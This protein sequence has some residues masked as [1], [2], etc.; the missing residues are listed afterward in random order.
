MALS[1]DLFPPPVPETG[2]IARMLAERVDACRLSPGIAVGITEAG[3]RRYVTHGTS[4]APGSRAID[5]TT[6]FEIGSITKLF[7]AL[8]LAE[9]TL[10]G[11]TTL[12][13]PV[14]QLLP[15]GVSVPAWQERQ[16][17]LLD[18]ATH[19]SGL[20]RLPAN[21]APNDPADPYAHYTEQ[22]LYDFLASH[23]LARSPAAAE[24]YSNIGA[25]LLGHALALRAGREYEALVRERILRPLGMAS[26]VLAVPPKLAVRFA[27]GHDTNPDPVPHWHLTTLAGAGG[28]RS[29]A[30]DL[31]TF[32]EMLM[33]HE[34]SPLGPAAALLVAPRDAGGLGL[35]VAQPDGS[36]VLSHGGGTGGFR[37]HVTCVAQ[38]RRGVA[39]LGNSAAD[40]EDLCAY[41]RD[42]RW[43][44]LWHRREAKVDPRGFTRLVGRYRLKPQIVIDVICADGHLLVQLSGQE[45]LRVFPASE[46]H[47]FYKLIGAQL[48]FEPGPDGR[49]ARL[50]LHQNNID[51]IAERIIPA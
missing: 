16:I 45:A 14:V 21:L 31:M 48:T 47:F 2:A 35:G 11:E 44:R 28:L 1:D 51:R 23:E 34:A 10:R 42:T 18:L 32:L 3:Q 7:T 4:G 22:H 29:C 38:W 24:E 26:T 33:D 37:S 6:L 49:A 43:G 19:L 27:Q 46:W 8:L 9:M 13:E 20:P 40:V 39:V 15:A 30:A 25:G 41:L 12:D 17:T 5:E 50:I 36:V